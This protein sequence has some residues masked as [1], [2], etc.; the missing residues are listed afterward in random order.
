MDQFGQDE[1]LDDQTSRD[2]FVDNKNSKKRTC[3]AAVDPKHSFEKKVTRK[4]ISRSEMVNDDLN[5]IR[6]FYR[7]T[8]VRRHETIESAMS[9]MLT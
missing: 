3:F 6:S 1:I 4:A 2:L 7:E 8:E 9:P 5:T